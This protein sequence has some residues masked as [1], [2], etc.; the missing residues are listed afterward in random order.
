MIGRFGTIDR[1]AE[2]YDALTPYQYGGLNPVSTIDMNGDSIEIIYDHQAILYERGELYGTV[3][4]KYT[5]NGAKIGKDGNV[6]GYKGFLGETKKALDQIGSG[7]N[8]NFRRSKRR[9]K[10]LGNWRSVTSGTTSKC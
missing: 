10:R 2:K 6:S 9:V 4:K 5:G 1:Y 8:G 7:K 3:G